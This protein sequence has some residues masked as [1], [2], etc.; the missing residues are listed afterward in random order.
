VVS[1]NNSPNSVT[2]LLN[3]GRGRLL[4]KLDYRT[5][6]FELL[7]VAAADVNGDRRV[8]IVTAD[9]DGAVFAF[10]N[11][12]GFCN[13]QFVKNLKLAA[14]KAKLRRAHCRV[15]RV[16]F[17]YSNLAKG[18]ALKQCPRFGVVRPAGA[19]VDLVVSLGKG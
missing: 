7:S 11:R 17:A 13:V 5:G 6:G 10:L 14:A 19:R 12:P 15:G 16:S 18:L 9:G 3:R 2:L 8:D 4:P 1:N